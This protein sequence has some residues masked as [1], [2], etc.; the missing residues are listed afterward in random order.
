MYFYF[1]LIALKVS[2]YLKIILLKIIFAFS[3]HRVVN[4]F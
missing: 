1:L 4:Y 3:E 2:E